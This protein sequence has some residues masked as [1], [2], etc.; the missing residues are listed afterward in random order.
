VMGDDR[1]GYLP[2]HVFFVP[3][4]FW[5]QENLRWVWNLIGCSNLSLASMSVVLG[6]WE[7]TALPDFMACLKL[8]P[9]ICIY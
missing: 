3:F 2:I 4:W 6:S 8:N 5:R 1:K 9:G 7:G